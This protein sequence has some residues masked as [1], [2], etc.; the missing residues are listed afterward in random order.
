[1]QRIFSVALIFVAL[2]VS[3]V[4]RAQG[5]HD[6]NIRFGKVDRPGIIAEFPY[7]KGITENALRARFEKVGFSKPKSDKGFMSYQAAKWDEMSATQLDVY[8][9][10]DANGKDNQSTVILLVSK[11]YDNYVSAASDPTMSA[12]LK[13]F[14]DGLAPDIQA[15]QRLADIGAQE[16][17]IR[18]A[19]K[20][21]KSADDDGN[22]LLRDKEKIEKQIAENNTEKQKR[23]DALNSLKTQLEQM[24]AGTK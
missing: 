6:A 16:E 13:A 15:G 14:L 2:L 19:E 12:K 24:R 17:S 5:A 10:V 20:D 23:G 9:K 8:A 4:L 3:P 7:S 11:G 1:M 22:R 21:F 18:R